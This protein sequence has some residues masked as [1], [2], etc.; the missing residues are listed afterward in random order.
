VLLQ[1][2]SRGLGLGLHCFMSV[3]NVYA[4]YTFLLLKEVISGVSLKVLEISEIK[5]LGPWI[6]LTSLWQNYSW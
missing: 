4:R 2:V 1:C 6:S 3:C 5:E